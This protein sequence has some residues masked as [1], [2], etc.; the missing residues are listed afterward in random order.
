MR[1]IQPYTSKDRPPCREKEPS[2][3]I[4]SLL[5]AAV[6]TRSD[7]TFEHRASRASIKKR[8]YVPL[9]P[10]DTPNTQATQGHSRQR[11]R[12][13][14]HAGPLTSRRVNAHD[15]QVT[16]T[17]TDQEYCPTCPK[18]RIKRKSRGTPRQVKTRRS[19]GKEA[20]RG[21]ESPLRVVV[22]TRVPPVS[23]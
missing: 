17:P 22:R 3:K 16:E 19:P 23:S 4:G 15:A 2:K 7:V 5:Y 11:A 14:R 6:T 10:S 1:T 12:Y 20:K 21:L 9:R 18:K 8:R 13:V